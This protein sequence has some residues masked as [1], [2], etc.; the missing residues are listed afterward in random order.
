MD[1]NDEEQP[2]S[3]REAILQWIAKRK[4]SQKSLGPQFSRVPSGL[5]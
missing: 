4:V 5:P 2:Y 1:H 3:D